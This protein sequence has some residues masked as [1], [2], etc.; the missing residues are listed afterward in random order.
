MSASGHP[1]A[2]WFV[3]SVTAATG[4]RPP[5]A[6]ASVPAGDIY[7]LKITLRGV[8]KPPVWRRIAVPAGLTLDLLHEVIQQAMGWEDGHMHVFSTPRGRLRD[9]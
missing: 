1:D 7:Q 2:A 4:I 3:E 5:A 8:S 9:T 6:P